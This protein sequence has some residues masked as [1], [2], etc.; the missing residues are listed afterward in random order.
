MKQNLENTLNND[1]ENTDTHTINNNSQ[2]KLVQ[3]A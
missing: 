2:I 3:L 1:K